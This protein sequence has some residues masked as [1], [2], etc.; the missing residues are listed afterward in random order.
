ML[1]SSRIQSIIEELKA[2]ADIVLFDSPPILVVTDGQILSTRMDGVVLVTD[3][4]RTRTNEARRAAEELRRVHANLLG[5]VLNRLTP[6]SGGYYYYNYTYYNYNQGEEK[7]KSHRG[8]GWRGKVKSAA[9]AEV[10][11]QTE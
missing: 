1:I 7:K 8:N 5:M 2:W 6:R 4:G 10:H 9:S 3:A 11:S